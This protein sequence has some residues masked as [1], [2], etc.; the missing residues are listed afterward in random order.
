MLRMH[1]ENRLI[2]KQ[3]RESLG[4]ELVSARAIT[5]LQLVV[6]KMLNNPIAC[7]SIHNG[8]RTEWSPMRSVSY[9]I[10]VV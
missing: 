5:Q 3:R 8:N 2:D 1:K 6:L 7:C 4:G 10:R 9:I